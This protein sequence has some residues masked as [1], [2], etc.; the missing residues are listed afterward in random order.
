VNQQKIAG[1]NGE[2]FMEEKNNQAASL[3]IRTGWIS[4][5]VSILNKIVDPLGKAGLVIACFML[6]AMMF[7]TFFDVAGSMIGKTPISDFTSFFKPILGSQEVTELIM[8]IMISFALGCMALKKG[9]IRVDLILQYTSRKA[10]YWFDLFAYA[11]SCVFYIFISW[12]AV[13]LAFINMRDDMIS[14]ILAIPI[15]PFNILLGIGAAFVALIFLRDF[16]RSVEEV[17]Q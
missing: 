8:V 11:I 13:A 16:L 17:S 2:K 9:H 3:N 15:F 14:S 1:E 6:A 5:T 7:L 4:K 10:N 12:Q